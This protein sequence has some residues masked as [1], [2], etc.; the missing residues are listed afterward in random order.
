ML[1]LKIINGKVFIPGSGFF[2]LEVGI[3]DG[4]IAALGNSQDMSDASEILDAGGNIVM[5][6]VIDPHIHLG[7]FCRL[8]YG[9]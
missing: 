3:K 2:N 6:G 7:Y 4:K 5:P 8:C 9:M 1:D